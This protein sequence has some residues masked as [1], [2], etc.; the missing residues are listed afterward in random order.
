MQCLARIWLFGNRE[1]SIFREDSIRSEKHGFGY[2]S[3][4]GEVLTTFYLTGHGRE[5]FET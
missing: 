3:I 4:S 5:W 1:K 2:R